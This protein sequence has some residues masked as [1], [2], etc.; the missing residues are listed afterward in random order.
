VFLVCCGLSV[1]C[2]CILICCVV[3]VVGCWWVVLWVGCWFLCVVFWGRFSVLFGFCFVFVWG[4]L[5]FACGGLCGE[6]VGVVLKWVWWVL[7]RRIVVE[8]F[9]L[10]W[11]EVFAFGGCLFWFEV[12]TLS[13]V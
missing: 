6:R 13:V 1:A 10:G 2:V 7:S 12:R 11:C 8:A 5:V 3:L 4:V 9:A